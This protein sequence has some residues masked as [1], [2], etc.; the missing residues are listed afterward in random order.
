MIYPVILVVLT[1][2]LF[3][4]SNKIKV[5]DG[6]FKDGTKDARSKYSFWGFVKSFLTASLITLII[7]FILGEGGK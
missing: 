2:I 4:N 5:K 6:R 3:L 7:F 1:I